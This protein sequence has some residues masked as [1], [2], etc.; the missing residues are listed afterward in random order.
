MRLHFYCV[1]SSEGDISYHTTEC[2]NS[3]IN[4]L[5]CPAL[6]EIQNLLLI[7]ALTLFQKTGI[8]DMNHLAFTI[9]NYKYRESETPCIIKTLHQSLALLKFLCALR[10]TWAVVHMDILEVGSNNITDS[11]IIR[12]EVSKLQAPGH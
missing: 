2:N 6:E 5:R 1:T 4:S 3:V 8:L 12:D 9:E 10:F 7:I 11:C